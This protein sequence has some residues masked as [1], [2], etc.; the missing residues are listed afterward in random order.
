MCFLRLLPFVVVAGII[1]FT[2]LK[3]EPVPQM[4]D[5][6]D[7]LHH[8]LGFAAF[9]LALHLAFP[10]LLTGWALLLSLSLALGIE[11]AQGLQPYRHASVGD[12]AA[13]TLGVMLGWACWLRL[14]I[15]L[16]RHYPALLG[17][18]PRS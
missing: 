7:K 1:L 4:F 3:P 2:G 12:M 6:Q 5:Q 9:A 8:L 18:P 15:G 13:N 11:M 17:L 10:R 16:L 14:R